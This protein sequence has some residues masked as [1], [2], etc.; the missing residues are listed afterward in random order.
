M[1]HQIKW[2]VLYIYMKKNCKQAAICC[3]HPAGDVG[4]RAWPSAPPPTTAAPAPAPADPYRRMI[5]GRA[6]R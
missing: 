1:H 3:R 2:F 5:C 4:R 6:R